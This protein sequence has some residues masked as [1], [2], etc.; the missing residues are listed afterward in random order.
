M[1]HVIHAFQLINNLGHKK[2]NCRESSLLFPHHKIKINFI[3]Q[4]KPL[5]Y[6]KAKEAN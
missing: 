6:L 2:A 1:F 3:I 4:L 5:L